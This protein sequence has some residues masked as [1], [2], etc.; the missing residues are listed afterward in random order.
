M[1]PAS[2]EQIDALWGQNASDNFGW[3]KKSEKTFT[4]GFGTCGTTRSQVG[5]PMPVQIDSGLLIYRAKGHNYFIGTY[6]ASG[7]FSYDA[8][9]NPDCTWTWT[10]VLYGDLGTFTASTSGTAADIGSTYTFGTDFKM[11]IDLSSYLSEGKWGTFAHNAYGTASDFAADTAHLTFRHG[12]N[13][14][15]GFAL[16]NAYTTWV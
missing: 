2:G 11:S 5:G 3:V 14:P 7:T 8:A 15:I 9:G 13:S 1:K 10:P 6:G 12:G 4:I 16:Y